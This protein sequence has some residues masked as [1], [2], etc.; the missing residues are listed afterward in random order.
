VPTAAPIGDALAR[1]AD[2]LARAGCAIGRADAD[3]P[4]LRAVSGLFTELLSAFMSV[5]SP[6]PSMTHRDWVLGDRRRFALAA[7]WR[8]LFERW[9][10]VLTP[11][12]PTTAFPHDA[13]SFDAR[14]LAVDGR[15]VSYR[16]LP[17][18]T[19][20]P[21]PTGHPAATMPI[22]RDDAGLPIGVQIIGPRL[23]D[24]TPI[25]FAGLVEQL[26]GGFEAPPA[27]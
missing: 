7:R 8:R 3:L 23:E 27:S 5:D 20:L 18:W 2:D 21:T 24:R 10:V 13:R 1:L 26:R 9:D 25:T 14:T 15:D 17:L 22:G 4:D 19:A 11:T 12:A 16:L 6:G